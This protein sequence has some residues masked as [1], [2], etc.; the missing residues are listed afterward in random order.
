MRGRYAK[1]VL[2]WNVQ[3]GI[4]EAETVVQRRPGPTS[5][6]VLQGVY[7]SGLEGKASHLYI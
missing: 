4:T 2:M 3:G 6:T 7:S 5:T 1:T